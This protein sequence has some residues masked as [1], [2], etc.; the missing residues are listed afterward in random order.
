MVGGAI[1]SGKNW[2]VTEHFCTA[3]GRYLKQFIDF[4]CLKESKIKTSVEIKNEQYKRIVGEGI[5]LR[6]IAIT[7]YVQFVEITWEAMRADH[8]HL[9]PQ[10]K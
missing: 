6:K 9:Y 7:K 8:K 1:T 4:L 3:P 10:R 5:D 2:E